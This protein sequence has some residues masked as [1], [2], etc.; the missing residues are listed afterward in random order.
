MKVLPRCCLVLIALFTIIF[1]LLTFFVLI[2]T[3]VFSGSCGFIREINKDKVGVLYDLD[4]NKDVRD[5]AERCIFS[6]STGEINSIFAK[7]DN[8]S[9]QNKKVNYINDIGHVINGASEYFIY[10]RDLSTPLTSAALSDVITSWDDLKS[11]V[12]VD[13]DVAQ[14]N[15]D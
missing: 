13:F 12:T 3:V 5:L 2:G 7:D 9:N 15:L 14:T 8:I 4:L 1:A 6:N 11:G 10:K